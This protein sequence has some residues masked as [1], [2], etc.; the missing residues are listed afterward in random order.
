MRR[1]SVVASAEPVYSVVSVNE[2]PMQ[3]SAMRWPGT[4]SSNGTGVVAL[5]CATP[6]RRRSAR[7]SAFT[8]GVLGGDKASH[9]SRG[10]GS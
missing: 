7:R 4:V 8:A 1:P 2:M 5:A 6:S 3:I 9:R 10:R